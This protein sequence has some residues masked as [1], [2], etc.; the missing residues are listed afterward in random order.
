[1]LGEPTTYA[2][3]PAL[4]ADATTATPSL[5]AFWAATEVGSSAPPRS[6]PSDMLITLTPSATARFMARSTMLLEPAHP[7]TRYA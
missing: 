5:K 7:N 3:G 1:M 4:P 2:F 6:E